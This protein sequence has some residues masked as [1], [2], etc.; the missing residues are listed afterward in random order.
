MYVVELLEDGEIKEYKYISEALS[1]YIK[2]VLFENDIDEGKGNEDV[3]KLVPIY[4]KLWDD[5]NLHLIADSKN[6]IPE[7]GCK[8]ILFFTTEELARGD[9]DD[10]IYNKSRMVRSFFERT[11][12]AVTANHKDIFKKIR[13]LILEIGSNKKE[14]ISN[15]FKKLSEFKKI[16]DE[17][18]IKEKFCKSKRGKNCNPETCSTYWEE[19]QRLYTYKSFHTI[20]SHEITRDIEKNLLYCKKRDF[21]KNS[22]DLYFKEF[23]Y[24]LA[25]TVAWNPKRMKKPPNILIIDDNEDIKEEWKEILELMP[26]GTCAYITK[27]VKLDRFVEDDFLLKGDNEVELIKVN[28]DG[29]ELD[30]DKF[31]LF[32][33]HKFRFSHVIVD[34]LIGS[35]NKGNKII[36][37]LLRLRHKLGK[38]GYDSKFDIIASSLS[39]EVEDIH[40]ALEEGAIAFVPKKRI[41]SLP[42]VISRL[43]E[44]REGLP[45]KKSIIAKYRNFEKLYKLPE[46]IKRRLHTEALAKFFDNKE[47]RYLNN[48]SKNLALNWIKKIPKAELHFHIGGSMNADMVFNL[49]LN[50]LRHINSSWRKTE[51]Q[52]KDNTDKNK[53]SEQFRYFIK[54]SKKLLD[55]LIN[56]LRKNRGKEHDVFLKEK[57]KFKNIVF[58]EKLNAIKDEFLNNVKSWINKE[59]KIK[60]GDKKEAFLITEF[61]SIGEPERWYEEILEIPDEELVFKFK[62]WEIQD[63]LCKQIKRNAIKQDDVI[64]LFI[65][66]LGIAEGRGN[67]NVENFWEI[68]DEINKNIDLEENKGTNDILKLSQKEEILDFL[69]NIEKTIKDKNSTKKIGFYSTLHNLI[70]AEKRRGS[71]KNYLRGNL[72]CGALHLQ[73]YENIFMCVAHLIKEAADDNIRYLEIRVSPEGYIREDLTTQEAIEALFNAAD[74]M[75]QYL[76]KKEKYI[77]TNFIVTAKRHKTPEERAIEI[78]SAIVHRER[79]IQKGEQLKRKRNKLPKNVLTSLG[80]EWQPSR[81]VGVDLAGLEKGYKPAQFEED[82]APLFKTCSF[83]TI[84]AGEE[85]SAQ[86]IW[87]AVY[88]L[89]AHRIGHGLTLIR[90]RFLLDLAKNT[91]ICL[92]M[93]PISNIFTS[94]DLEDKYPLYDYIKKGICVTIN[95][96]DKAWSNSSLSE[97]YVKSAE[98]YWRRARNENLDDGEDEFLKKWEVLRIVKNGFKKAFID[99]EER[100]ELLKAV[101]E[102]IYQL[103]LE[104]ERVEKETLLSEKIYSKFSWC[105]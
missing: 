56:E 1:R 43:E 53:L 82:F 23:L 63:E 95:T 25:F 11:T 83:I 100:R 20:T 81:I 15:S 35:H 78:S 5:N 39:D 61:L 104:F 84:H 73:Y 64:S 9:K 36:R 55:P 47:R 12:Y 102:E 60:K 28:S 45:G 41:Y 16:I 32:K 99:R 8:A 22:I 66:F 68:I 87:E 48:I 37:N 26:D 17:L 10:S 71:L 7:L 67:E 94:P 54:E 96:D 13:E 69:N 14:D 101:E 18:K 38:D 93:A 85:G 4:K 6:N 92:E 3:I 34:L 62:T 21:F 2:Y 79:V 57:S 46:R 27:N 86:N 52:N 42:G 90:H 40:R 88:K 76:Y 91:Q 97:E 33:N 30:G 80:Y 65:V 19:M 29:K 77:W 89:N 70:S 50:N 103:I 49:A 58:D 51:K 105:P 31:S 72:F 74:L 98:L 75:S 59:D 24:D 44:S